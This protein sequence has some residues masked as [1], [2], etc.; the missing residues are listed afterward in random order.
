LRG[1]YV[2]LCFWNGGDWEQHVNPLGSPI[3][4]C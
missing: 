3:R 2:D 4:V 1:R